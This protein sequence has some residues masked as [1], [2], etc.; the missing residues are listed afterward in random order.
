MPTMRMRTT[1]KTCEM[2]STGS[3]TRVSKGAKRATTPMNAHSRL[4]AHSKHESFAVSE[5]Y[6]GRARGAPEPEDD[7]VDL[8]LALTSGNRDTLYTM[9][10]DDYDDRSIYS[11]VSILDPDKSGETR[12]RFV[13]R[14]EAML[15][16]K[17]AREGAPVVPPVPKI[18]EGL[19]NASR[20]NRF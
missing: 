14:V 13:R 5:Y 4:D 3:T 9:E 15:R 10:D 1:R 12:D 2:F 20:P 6:G 17:E 11:R 8:A 18:P 16:A 7:D 19:A